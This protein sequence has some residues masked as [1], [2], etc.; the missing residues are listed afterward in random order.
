MRRA[1]RAFT[2]I[3]AV[4]LAM[5]ALL[6]AR[7][8]RDRKKGVSAAITD[9][10]Q[11]TTYIDTIPYYKPVPRDSVIVRYI[12]ETLPLPDTAVRSPADTGK[13]IDSVEVRIPIEQ[14]RYSDSTYTAYI[15]GY[16]PEIDSIVVYPRHEVTTVTAM[17]TEYKDQWRRWSVGITAGYGATKDG[18]SPYVGVGL[19]WSLFRF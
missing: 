6:N 12:T 19:T 2:G 7:L 17:R 15:S 13:T 10:A 8:L 16:R 4:L 14:K 5:S 1:G 3:L 18:L 11:T 9:T